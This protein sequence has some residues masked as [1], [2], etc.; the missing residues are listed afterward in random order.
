MA[1]F[2]TELMNVGADMS[3]LLE[4][5]TVATTVAKETAAVVSHRTV[6]DAEHCGYISRGPERTVIRE[7]GR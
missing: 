1:V 6:R 4:G 7:M 2:Q 3:S 5:E